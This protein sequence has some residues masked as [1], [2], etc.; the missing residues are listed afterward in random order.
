LRAIVLKA[1]S[2][3]QKQNYRWTRSP[4]DVHSGGGQRS[5]QSTRFNP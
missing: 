1:H 2:L 3:F 4:T 5:G